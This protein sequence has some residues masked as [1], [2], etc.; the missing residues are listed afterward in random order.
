M[1]VSLFSAC[2]L[3]LAYAESAINTLGLDPVYVTSPTKPDASVNGTSSNKKLAALVY[4]DSK[5]KYVFMDALS[6]KVIPSSSQP[7]NPNLTTKSHCRTFINRITGEAIQICNPWLYAH[8]NKPTPN[9][10]VNT[11]PTTKSECISY[12]DDFEG[13]WFEFCD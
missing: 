3:N 10:P 8:T 4:V 1:D 2:F 12:Y 11:M 6:G 9:E 5:G 13:V 7:S